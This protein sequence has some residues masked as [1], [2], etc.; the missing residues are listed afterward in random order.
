MKTLKLSA[1]DLF[2]KWSTFCVDWF[3]NLFAD[4]D[5]YWV[6]E[7]YPGRSVK[8]SNEINIVNDKVSVFNPIVEV[9]STS[10]PVNVFNN[11]KLSEKFRDFRLKLSSQV[12]N[13]VNSLAYISMEYA[14]INI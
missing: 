4:P 9:I 2:V 6:E 11:M 1:D 8:V 10:K 14:V 7:T 12:S 3:M 13:I 5:Y